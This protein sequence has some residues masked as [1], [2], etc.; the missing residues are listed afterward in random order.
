MNY[1][2]A[3]YQLFK[4]TFIKCLSFV[5][6]S[7]LVIGSPK[8]YYFK[9]E[10]FLEKNKTGGKTIFLHSEILDT[11]KSFVTFFDRG[12]TSREK[13]KTGLKLI[14]RLNVL[15]R[16]RI[17]LDP[18]AFITSDDKLLFEESSCYG[19]IPEEHWIFR[20]FKLDK[21]KRLKGKVLFLSCRKNYWH[22]LMDDIPTLF[23][24]EQAGINI[25][26]FDFVICEKNQFQAAFELYEMSGIK[27]KK[28]VSLSE[29]RHFL[30]EELYFVTGTFALSPES[31]IFTR[32][33]VIGE[34]E[35]EKTLNKGKKFIITRDDSPIRRWLNQNECTNKLVKLGFEIISTSLLSIKEQ[36]NLFRQA[37]MII[38]VHGAGLT[39]SLFM[40]EG[41][42]V[43]EIRAIQQGGEYSS[44]ECYQNLSAILHHNHY[45]F[46]TRGYE[47][48]E[49][50]G[51]S[52][53][54]ADLKPNSEELFQCALECTKKIQH[55]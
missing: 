37:S 40:R 2:K 20:K 12:K 15:H 3:Y 21:V 41:S 44:A 47:R 31:L 32:R 46:L 9:I 5:S 10:E 42:I 43:L 45:V 23:F 7:S 16:G 1:L 25:T 48:N 33:K 28:V 36:A 18:W 4:K 39:N 24:L 51:R 34:L 6:K 17:H 50:K 30:C 8:G 49:L 52:I 29:F 35:Y 53:E 14:K 38:G 55:L 19:K 11:P 13:V 27:S 54:D 22:L 26:N